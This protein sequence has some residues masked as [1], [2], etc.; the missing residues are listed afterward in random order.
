MIQY[1]NVFAMYYSIFTD[2]LALSYNIV[3]NAMHF[4]IHADK[5]DVQSRKYEETLFE[6]E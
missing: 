6:I 5:I 3:S 4:L 1:A 2:C